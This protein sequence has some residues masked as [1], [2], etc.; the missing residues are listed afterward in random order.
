MKSCINFILYS[1]ESYITCHYCIYS[2]VHYSPLKE[3]HLLA[4]DATSAINYN[5]VKFKHALNHLA[6]SGL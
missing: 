1:L 5:L 6:R 2:G 3:K 4:L